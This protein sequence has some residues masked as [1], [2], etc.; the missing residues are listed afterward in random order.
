MLG[1]E[2]RA[3]RAATVLIEQKKSFKNG[4]SNPFQAATPGGLD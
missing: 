3:S 1:A 2:P 4:S